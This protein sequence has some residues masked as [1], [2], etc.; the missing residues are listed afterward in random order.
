MLKVTLYPE[1]RRPLAVTRNKLARPVP[2]RD[3][4][5]DIAG[6]TLAGPCRLLVNGGLK[7]QEAR[8]PLSG[9]GDYARRVCRAGVTELAFKF[10]PAG[11]AAAPE[12]RERRVRRLMSKV[13]GDPAGMRQAGI[14]VEIKHPPFDRRQLFRS[15]VTGKVAFKRHIPFYLIG[16]AYSAAATARSLGGWLA[17]WESGAP[18]LA[19]AAKAATLV[20]GAA[21]GILCLIPAARLATALYRLARFSQDLSVLTAHQLGLKVP[22]RRLDNIFA[23]LN[24]AGQVPINYSKL[25]P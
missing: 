10:V 13:T 1:L 23:R 17:A 3:A 5:S 4:A 24:A 15:L 21:F 22:S 8:W 20:A 7:Y 16:G 14:E 18:K 19:L 2:P 12:A 11:P 9:S 6:R 25:Y